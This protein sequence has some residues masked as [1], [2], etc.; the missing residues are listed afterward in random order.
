[1]EHGLRYFFNQV[2]DVI[3]TTDDLQ[4]LILETLRHV[5]EGNHRILKHVADAHRTSD[6]FHPVWTDSVLGVV[7]SAFFP[8][9][10]FFFYLQGFFFVICEPIN[11]QSFAVLPWL[12]YKTVHSD[13]SCVRVSH[14]LAGGPGQRL[15]GHRRREILGPENVQS[16]NIVEDD[17]IITFCC[18]Q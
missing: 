9:H 3:G 6:H 17:M 15:L 1:V 11:C 14:C 5:S 7:H 4:S 8:H 13:R 2:L 18:D 16:H 10:Q 12:K